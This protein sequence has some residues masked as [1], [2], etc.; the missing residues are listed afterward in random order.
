[1][2]FFP[3]FNND[4]CAKGCTGQMDKGSQSLVTQDQTVVFEGDCLLSGN[5][6]NNNRKGRKNAKMD[7][8][9]F[10][11]YPKRTFIDFFIY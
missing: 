7:A 10:R 5:T 9:F 11:N 6:G 3:L 1:M 4:L 2:F 8:V